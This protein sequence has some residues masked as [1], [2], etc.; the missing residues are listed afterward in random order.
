MQQ[1]TL[2]HVKSALAL[3]GFDAA[4]AQL[5]MAPH[6]RGSFPLPT[7]P[8]KQAAVLAL[9]YP[10]DPAQ[11]EEN[12]QLVLTRRT[13][14]LRG[15]SGQVSF[16][17][18]RRDDEDDSFAA[19]A[20]RETCEELGLCD[21]PIIL[22]GHLSE[23]YIIPTGFNVHPYVG[24]LPHIPIFTPNPHEVA[25]VFSVPLTDLLDETRKCEEDREF[26]NG[27]RARVPYYDL[28]GHVVWGATA[29]ML[30]ELEH[31][32]RTVL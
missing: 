18:G 4:A 17:G 29:N 10:H 22:L 26:G 25:V 27:I 9:L 11:P 1:I 14:T 5:R 7:I 16:P 2:D 13:D 30:S 21:E 3:T 12:L 19:T 20:L 28:H 8:P 32:L 23:L 31:R 6:I 15:H 24:Y